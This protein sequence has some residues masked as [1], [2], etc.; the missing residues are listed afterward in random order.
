MCFLNHRSHRGTK[1][2]I[3]VC[4]S[5]HGHTRWEYVGNQRQHAVLYM[6]SRLLAMPEPSVSAV[7]ARAGL[8][9]V[10]ERDCSSGFSTS[11][12]EFTAS[13]VCVHSAPSGGVGVFAA[14]DFAKGELLLQERWLLGAPSCETGQQS[15]EAVQLTQAA[16]N[17]ND[18]AC[19][20]CLRVCAFDPDEGTVG[21]CCGCGA[22]YCTAACR[23]AAWR[24]YHR[25]LC[26]SVATTGSA[27]SVQPVEVFRKHANLA[28]AHIQQKPED[29]LLAAEMLA[30]SVLCADG[31]ED[32]ERDEL[33]ALAAAAPTRRSMLPPP[34]DTFSSYCI[35]TATQRRHPGGAKSEAA[36]LCAKWVNDSYRLL[37]ASELGKHPRFRALC[38]PPVYS[39][40]LGLLDRNGA[41]AAAVAAPELQALRTTSG[42]ASV[43]QGK[44]A[45]DRGN[46]SW[47][48]EGFGLYR[49]FSCTNHSCGPNAVNAKGARDDPD[50]MLDNSLVLR[51]TRAIKAGEEICF[52]YLDLAHTG[53]PTT[54]TAQRRQRLQEHFGF[55]CRCATCLLQLGISGI[56]PQPAP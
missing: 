33:A 50:A 31:E 25:L 27:T 2:N 29:V 3:S 44:G 9:L 19:V 51:A 49:T 48:V 21:A 24:R 32:S 35:V 47:S 4:F 10:E 43:S 8:R 20:H 56:D 6:N 11:R 15:G 38:P 12:W 1:H 23:A 13:G 45:R 40:A 37:S 41:C 42:L 36:Q 7:A 34:F 22:R 55:E 5:I 26:V 54:G 30:M 53:Q 39:H 18:R 14:R 46:K 52:D 16:R 28:P 17:K